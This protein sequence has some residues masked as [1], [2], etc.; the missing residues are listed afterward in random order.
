MQRFL[1]AMIFAGAAWGADAPVPVS[2][3]P[4]IGCDADRINEAVVLT[5]VE[6]TCWYA[7]HLVTW[8]SLAGATSSA[9]INQAQESPGKWHRGADG[10]AKRFGAA[11]AAN[12]AK[13][14][15]EFLTTFAS[16]EELR[17]IPPDNPACGHSHQPTPASFG[18][19]LGRSLLASVWVHGDNCRD[20]VAWSRI[21]G[22]FASGFIG[23]AWLPARDN[24]VASA[25]GRTGTAMAGNVGNSVFR[26]F[27]P[28]LLHLGARLIGRGK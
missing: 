22:S 13:T 9:W 19:R 4:S 27:Q 11:Y 7:D 1:L 28:D 18:K 15:T 2:P 6:K 23:M 8:T 21:T 12:V 26:E 16:H 25:F 20:T 5:P 14:T 10:W 17:P 24:T 3:L